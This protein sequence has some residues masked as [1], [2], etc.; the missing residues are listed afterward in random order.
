MKRFAFI[1]LHAPQWPVQQQRQLLGV[2]P[3]GYYARRK[4]PVREA[5]AA[6]MASWQVAAPRVFTTHAHRYGQR[7]SRAQ[8]QREGRAVGRHRLRSWTSASGLRALSTQNWP[9][10]STTITTRNACTL[11]WATARPPKSNSN[12][13]STYLNPSC[14]VIGGAKKVCSA[15]ERLGLKYSTPSSPVRHDRTDRCN[16]LLPR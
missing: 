13:F 16:V 4:C 14:G 12:I 8:P 15:E 3:S 9:S 6:P 7:R 1:H 11:L 2:G 5:V 10:T